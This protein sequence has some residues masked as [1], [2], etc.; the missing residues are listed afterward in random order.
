[1]QTITLTRPGSPVSADT[2]TT[3]SNLAVGLFIS[4]THGATWAVPAPPIEIKGNEVIIRPPSME[5]GRPYLFK[6]KGAELIAIRR[7]YEDDVDIYSIGPIIE[8]N[9]NGD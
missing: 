7:T 2:P 4:E 1:M 6:F 9:G 5:V 3:H 8:D